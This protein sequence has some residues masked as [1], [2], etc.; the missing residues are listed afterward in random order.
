MLRCL[1]FQLIRDWFVR[2]L[3]WLC[4]RRWGVGLQSSFVL[5][6]G[7]Q[8][9]LASCCRLPRAVI[10][11]QGC[12]QRQSRRTDMPSSG[13]SPCGEFIS[14]LSM[15]GGELMR[16]KRGRCFSSAHPIAVCL[17]RTGTQGSHCSACR[18]CIHV[19]SVCQAPSCLEW[20]WSI[21]GGFVVSVFSN[22]WNKELWS[23]KIVRRE[24]LIF[25]LLLSTAPF[26]LGAVVNIDK[27]ILESV[28]AR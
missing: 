19:L 3:L 25:L 5:G 23:Q 15:F 18:R 6:F 14:V 4:H 26:C 21:L 13:A 1:V 17:G 2:H 20:Y 24:W 7:D 9:Q 28:N 8:T 16:W 10:T 22:K 27:C 12:C 11:L